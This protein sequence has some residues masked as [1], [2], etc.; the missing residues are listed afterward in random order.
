[1]RYLALSFLYKKPIVPSGSVVDLQNKLNDIA[2]TLP[3][4]FSTSDS[5]GAIVSSQ[6]TL[7]RNSATNLLTLTIDRDN[8]KTAKETAEKA[9]THWNANKNFLLTVLTERIK[10]FQKV[11]D[12]LNTKASSTALSTSEQSQ[13]T[14]AEAEVN[15][16][17]IALLEVSGLEDKKLALIQLITDSLAKYS[18]TETQ[19]DQMAGSLDSGATGI[20]WGYDDRKTSTD[21]TWKGFIATIINDG[22]SSAGEDGYYEGVRGGLLMGL[23]E[24][25]FTQL[26]RQ[27]KAGTKTKT[28]LVNYLNSP[29][30]VYPGFFANTISNARALGELKTIDPAFDDTKTVTEIINGLAT[31]TTTVIWNT[32]LGDIRTY[33]NGFDYTT[34]IADVRN[35]AQNK[36]AAQD[37]LVGINLAGATKTNLLTLIK[38]AGVTAAI[39]KASRWKDNYEAL[40]AKGDGNCFLNSLAILLTGQQIDDSTAANPQS[41]QNIALRLRVAVCLNLMAQADWMGNDLTVLD[42]PHSQYDGWNANV[43]EIHDK[44]VAKRCDG[45]SYEVIPEEYWESTSSRWKTNPHYAGA[46]SCSLATN[47]NYLANEDAVYLARLLERPITVVHTDA[48]STAKSPTTG[49]ILQTEVNWELSGLP[50]FTYPTSFIIWNASSN[51][52]EPLVQKDIHQEGK[53]KFNLGKNPEFDNSTPATA[54]ILFTF[55]TDPSD[56]LEKSLFSAAEDSR[57]AGL[58]LDAITALRVTLDYSQAIQQEW[59]D[60][61]ETIF[62]SGD[63]TGRRLL[64][65]VIRASELQV[66]SGELVMAFEDLAEIDLLPLP[67]FDGVET[68][69]TTISAVDV[70]QK[71]YISQIKSKLRMLGYD[72]DEN[73]TNDYQ[74]FNRFL[75]FPING[76]FDNWEEDIQDRNDIANLK[77]HMEGSVRPFRLVEEFNI[78]NNKSE[79]SSADLSAT[80]TSLP[81]IKR[82]FTEMV[83]TRASRLGLDVSETGTNKA[84]Y[85]DYLFNGTTTPTGGWIGAIRDEVDVD[86][87][88]NFFDSKLWVAGLKEI[89]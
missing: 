45:V 26:Y 49:G 14:D 65:S 2:A 8:Q 35:W 59:Y 58:N 13:K 29:E 71:W 83:L 6:L 3:T 54:S 40:R 24:T 60:N 52:Y 50:K 67:K 28:D 70:A 17:R 77:F 9:L 80:A 25:L 36:L 61:K 82:E 12:D 44:L 78:L 87:L 81:A 85:D 4:I 69:P 46:T 75:G 32:I 56:K 76:S 27:F 7:L 55:G 18:V 10:Q 88:K 74:A 38:S 63:K 20:H 86:N 51:H 1:M 33:V 37:P 21:F 31:P 47:G 11:V 42:R 23:N 68:L 89:R 73:T 39:G 62:T 30:L 53:L 72:V 19:L 64:V 41:Q 79:L 48:N 57:L 84:D 34:Q 5:S 66:N 15:N 22:S 16:T 43:E